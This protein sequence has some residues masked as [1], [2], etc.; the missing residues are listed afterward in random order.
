LT[1]GKSG[2]IAST[3]VCGRRDSTLFKDK[4]LTHD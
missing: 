4:P 2:L 3:V 1:A